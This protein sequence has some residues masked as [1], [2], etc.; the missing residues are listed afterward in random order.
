MGKVSEFMTLYEYW[1]KLSAECDEFHDY[2]YMNYKDIKSYFESKKCNCRKVM[3]TYSSDLGIASPSKMTKYIVKNHK[4]GWIIKK[5]KSGQQYEVVCYDGNGLTSVIDLY[6]YF[7]NGSSDA[8]KSSTIY[9]INYNGSIWT[10]CFSERGYLSN[11][12]YKIVYDETQRLKGFYEIGAA[13]SLQVTAEEYDYSKIESGVMTCIYTYY[14]GRASGASK[15]IP[16]GYK[17]SPATQFKYDV[18]LDEKGRYKAITTYK[19]VE[20]EF[21]FIEHMDLTKKR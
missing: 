7:P 20:G 21:I 17:G 4:C 14:V 11:R 6:D 10:A 5:I 13:N 16:I 18:E 9:F 1:D 15:D 8:Q 19:N 2:A 12:H 3:S